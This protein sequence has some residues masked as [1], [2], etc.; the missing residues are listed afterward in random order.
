MLQEGVETGKPPDFA[1]SPGPSHPHLT[2]HQYLFCVSPSRRFLCMGICTCVSG[3]WWSHTTHA[4][5]SSCG[6]ALCSLAEARLQQHP[7]LCHEAGP[8]SAAS[9]I[10]STCGVCCF[11]ISHTAGPDRSGSSEGKV[12]GLWWPLTLCGF[13]LCRASVLAT[14]CL[15]SCIMASCLLFSTLRQPSSVLGWPTSVPGD[16]ASALCDALC[17]NHSLIAP[18]GGLHFPLLGFLF[19]SP[20]A[21][22]EAETGCLLRA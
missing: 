12:L 6:A 22:C 13:I 19:L 5:L 15:C 20:S 9:P 7:L 1:P 10:P 21:V 4:L 11:A 16:F 18:R 17:L 8:D 2:Q 14:G 3:S